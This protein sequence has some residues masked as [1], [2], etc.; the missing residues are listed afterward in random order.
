MPYRV[1]WQEFHR[2]LLRL[3]DTVVG[4]INRLDDLNSNVKKQ[5]TA[6]A[7]ELAMAYG[8]E[9]DKIRTTSRD[10]AAIKQAFIQRRKWRHTDAYLS[11]WLKTLYHAAV[12]QENEEAAVALANMVRTGVV[13]LYA[14]C[15]AA[16]DLFKPYA[17]KVVS[18]PLLVNYKGKS[19]AEDQR[20]FYLSTLRRTR[21]IPASER[22][23]AAVRH[24][25][26]REQL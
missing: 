12:E 19:G 10:L 13:M 5:V 25:N 8:I 21:L 16:P 17:R 20:F 6:D 23:K 1:T 7:L 2:R 9:L 18:W 15:A 24:A 11:H 26:G 4:R 3:V 22:H 14:A